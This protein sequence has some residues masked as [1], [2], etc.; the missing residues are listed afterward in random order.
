MQMPKSKMTNE[1]HALMWDT[2][3]IYTVR[4]HCIKNQMHSF[5]KTVITILYIFTIL[6]R[7]LSAC[8]TPHSLKVKSQISSRSALANAL[9]EYDGVIQHISCGGQLVIVCH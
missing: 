5:R 6:A 9:I 8:S 1:I 7:Y 3:D 2:N 4:C